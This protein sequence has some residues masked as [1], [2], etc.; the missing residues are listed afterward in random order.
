MAPQRARRAVTGDARAWVRRAA[1]VPAVLL[2]V[3]VVGGG[4]GAAILQS[5]GL[6]PWVGAP[7]LDAAA[8]RRVAPDL[9][10]SLLV[11]LA[12]ASA[13]TVIGAV[14]GLATALAIVGSSRAV[15]VLSKLTIPVPHLIGA[16]SIGLLLSDTGFL[17]RLLGVAPDGWPDFV[18]GRW[19]G[20]VVAEFAWKES[21]FIGLV[22]AA[23]LAT[24]AES[25]AET[26]A[27]LGATR[28]QRFRLV[29]WPLARPP[30][31]AASAI[32]YVYV[33]GSYEVALVLGRSHPEPL[34]VLAVRLASSN[35]LALRP[36][37]SAVAVATSGLCLLVLVA[38]LIALRRSTRTR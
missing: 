5:V 25:Y 10:S 33:L 35:Q 11:S 9:P 12:A 22:V 26:A 21:A 19:W 15:S 3:A 13:S 2:A 1:A 20:A 4:L 28:S 29:T 23:T 18:A 16:A 31:L 27:T 32:S 37:G 17:P 7:A 24:R 30:L 34:A 6:M 8:F 38:A 14:V 36:A